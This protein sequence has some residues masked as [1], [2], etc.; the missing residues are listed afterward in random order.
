MERIEVLR[1]TGIC[2]GQRL[3]LALESVPKLFKEEERNNM[4]DTYSYV[5]S[6][7]LETN[8]REILSLTPFSGQSYVNQRDMSP[9]GYFG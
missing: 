7:E 3:Q 5:S 6:E 1:S 4:F 9:R 2:H 8:I